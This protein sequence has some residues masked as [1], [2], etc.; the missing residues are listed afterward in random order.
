M[1]RLSH[2]IILIYYSYCRWKANVGVTYDYDSID[3]RKSFP[4]GIDMREVVATK[5]IR[6]KWVKLTELNK[7]D[8]FK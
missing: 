3:I 1:C 7:A 5:N 2:I 6:C 4:L 8:A